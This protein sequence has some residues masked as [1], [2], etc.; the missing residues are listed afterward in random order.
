MKLKPL[1]VAAVSSGLIFSSAPSQA[2]SVA[3]KSLKSI[4]A[5]KVQTF[6]KD[7]DGDGVTDSNDHCPNSKPGATVN[8]LGCTHDDA[9]GLKYEEKA[10]PRLNLLPPPK[11]AAPVIAPLPEPEISISSTFFGLD[12]YTLLPD[13]VDA[14]KEQVAQL[15][16]LPLA[17]QLLLIGHTCDLG[18]D[19]HNMILSQRRAE[20]VRDLILEVDPELSGRIAILGKGETSPK[21]PNTSEANRKQNRRVDVHIMKNGEGI[22][23]NAIK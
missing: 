22:P 8:Q 1:F 12:Q 14:L 9:F 19:A 6:Y 3:M 16:N 13:R 15:K 18:S 4:D 21:V 2:E 11:P 17:D 23:A 10:D 20:T 7:L 5:D